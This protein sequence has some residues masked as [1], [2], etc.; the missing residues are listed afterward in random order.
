MITKPEKVK[1]KKKN[2]LLMKL[3]EKYEDMNRPDS[4]GKGIIYV[5]LL[6]S[7]NE[8]VTDMIN[9]EYE[10]NMTIKNINNLEKSVRNMTEVTKV[11]KE[12]EEKEKLIL[13][14]NEL[15]LLDDIIHYRSIL[16]LFHPYS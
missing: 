4:N 13:Q 16:F 8:H 14:K 11:K 6:T 12:Q 5:F 10:L 9:E 3:V 7:D 15:K 2:D 1:Q